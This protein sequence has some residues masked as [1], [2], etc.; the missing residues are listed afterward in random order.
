MLV[1]GYLDLLDHLG[2]KAILGLLGLKAHLA[3]PVLIQVAVAVLCVLTGLL[4]AHLL[5]IIP[6]DKQLSIRAC[7][8]K[9]EA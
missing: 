2:L 5:S 1:R 8:L 9:I 3:L 7:K 4:R 6:V